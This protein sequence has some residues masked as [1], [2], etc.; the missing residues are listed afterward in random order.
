MLILSLFSCR[1]DCD[2]RIANTE[3]SGVAKTPPAFSKRV[4]VRITIWVTHATITQGTACLK[5]LEQYVELWQSVNK[6]GERRK[7]Q[8]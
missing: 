6:A 7:I 1:H 4:S 3:I 8:M 5:W 2:W